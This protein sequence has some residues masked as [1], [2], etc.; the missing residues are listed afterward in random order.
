MYFRNN[1]NSSVPVSKGF[2]SSKLF[3]LLNGTLMLLMLAAI[4]ALAVSLAHS[5]NNNNSTS[6]TMISECPVFS[7]PF[8][9]WTMLYFIISMDAY[10]FLFSFGFRV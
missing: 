4:I 9:S 10:N 2:F 8:F 6:T 5:L 1:A 7:R 3:T